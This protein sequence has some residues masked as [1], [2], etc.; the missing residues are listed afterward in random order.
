[1]AFWF[2]SDAAASQDLHS[3]LET[4]GGGVNVEIIKGIKNE[5]LQRFPLFWKS[6]GQEPIRKQISNNMIHFAKKFFL[7]ELSD[8]FDA[9]READSIVP[10][11]SIA[12]SGRGRRT[13]TDKPT[14]KWFDKEHC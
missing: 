12:G 13:S 8:L 6:E 7:R 14:D 4:R 5:V 3:L 1:M 10:L 11:R 9:I 2:A